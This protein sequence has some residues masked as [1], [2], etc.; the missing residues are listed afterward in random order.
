MPAIDTTLRLE[1]SEPREPHDPDLAAQA[2]PGHG[3]PSQ[4]PDAA[5][6][7]PLPPDEATREARS[8]LTGGGAVGGAAVGAAVGVLVGGP[9]GVLVGGPLGAIA[10]ALGAT[11]VASPAAQEPALDPDV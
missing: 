6:Q 5:A 3:V 11:A 2:V 9:V 10:G 1:P 7:V 8:V 4:D